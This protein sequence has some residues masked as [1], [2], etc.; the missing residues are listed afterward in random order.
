MTCSTCHDPHRWDPISTM[1]PGLNAEGTSQNSFLRLQNSPESTLCENCHEDQ[2]YIG[3]TDHDLRITADDSKNLSG[4]TPSQSGSCGVCHAVHSSENKP[5][6]WARNL[7]Q[8]EIVVDRMCNTCH[9][10]A[11]SGKNK[12]PHIATHPTDKLLT[13][14]TR[15]DKNRNDFFPLFDKVTGKPANV[16]DVACSTCHDVHR[17]SPTVKATGAGKNLEG[18]ATDSFLRHRK[19]NMACADCHGFDALFRFKYYHDP[20][21]RAPKRVQR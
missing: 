11:G 18:K 19:S 2:R 6:L 7:G 16:G 15:S 14:I 20:K 1:T 5:L 9:S 10:E 4:Q 3:G 12:I 21:K 13:N 8:G 17:W